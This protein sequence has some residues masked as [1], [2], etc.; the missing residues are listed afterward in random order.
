M[1]IEIW[2]SKVPAPKEKILRLRLMPS[3]FDANI[4]NL[5]AVDESGARVDRGNILQ[6]R[7]NGE[8]TR[9]GSIN[10]DIPVLRDN[11][12]FLRII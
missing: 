10:P 5:C 7:P 1:K 6:I 3:E 12:G 4:V 8:V 2:D 9:C 11:G